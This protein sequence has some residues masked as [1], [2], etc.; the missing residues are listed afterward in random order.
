[1]RF[2]SYLYMHFQFKTNKAGYTANKQS[3]AVGRGSN[4]GG[5]GQHEAGREL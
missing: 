5:Q 3:L 4:A 2:S 1:M